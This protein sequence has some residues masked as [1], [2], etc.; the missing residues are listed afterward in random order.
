[1]RKSKKTTTKGLNR[2]DLL[3]A[4]AAVGAVA[5]STKF[6]LFNINHA[7]S[8]DVHW[9]GQPFDAGG[10]SVIVGEWPGFWEEFV[11]TNMMNEFEKTYNCKIEYDGSWPWIAKFLAN[12][13]Q[14]PAY[15]TCNWNIKEMTQTA[16]AG[17]FFMPVDEIKANVPNA[18]DCWDFA[19]ETGIGVTWAFGQYC[20]VWRDDLVDPPITSFK[21]FWRDSLSGN[22]ASYITS[23]SLQMT[24]FMVA[25][26]V[27][28]ADEFDMEAGFDAMR[29]AMP[30]KVSDFTGNMQTLV[31]RGEVH[32]GV[33][34]EGEVY[35]Q[36]DKDI[37]VQPYVW[38]ER[39]PILT[40]TKT[41]SRYS[42]PMQ[43]KLSL[44]L[45]NET[46]EP[47]YLEKAAEVFYLRPANSKAV[48]PPNLAAKGVVNAA[49]AL[50]G[51]WIPDWNW[52][53]D[54]DDDITETVNEILAG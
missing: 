12:G 51:L 41:I 53:I 36:Q 14:D 20:Y 48:I 28:G 35:F 26:A 32:C 39:K 5:A 17:D 15:H 13:P 54:N 21:D 4:G 10:A 9:D 16:R 50:D 8:Q 45:L 42:D 23:N 44:A 22:R 30:M 38:T 40:Q 27:W 31:E 37:P 2:R 11:R 24:F 3:K 43:K 29:R 47:S 6:G 46:L 49:S 25:S 18:A 34:W 7:W 52:Y 1:M 19:F 33:Q